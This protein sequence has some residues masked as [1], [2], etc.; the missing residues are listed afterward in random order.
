MS[1]EIIDNLLDEPDE[2]LQMCKTSFYKWGERDTIDKPR[3]GMVCNLTPECPKVSK[4]LKKIFELKPEFKSKKL[5]RIYINCFAPSEQPYFH[6]DSE[7]GT[8]M[9][10]YATDIYDPDENGETQFLGKDDMIYGILPKP[11]RLV[12]F[13]ANLKHRATSFRTKHRFT[14]AIKFR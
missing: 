4:I 8:T 7:N 5:M 9:L 3:T 14:I 6:I 2:I 11:N 12:I 10:Y 13:D 1:I